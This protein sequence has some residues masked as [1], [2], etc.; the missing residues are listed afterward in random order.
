[1]DLRF[2]RS[3]RRAVA[4]RRE[5]KRR[6]PLAWRSV[7]ATIL[8]LV[9]LTVVAESTRLDGS[10]AKAK[11]VRPRRCVT[12]RT[13]RRAPRCSAARPGGAPL[14]FVRQRFLARREDVLHERR[15]LSQPLG[16]VAPA[17]FE[18]PHLRAQLLLAPADVSFDLP[19]HLLGGLAH[20]RRLTLRI[21]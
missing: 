17:L 15:D 19:H 9:L 12:P 7:Y 20:A 10:D 4:R 6:S 3:L 11:P 21:L 8:A 16:R 5:P 13:S 1:M 14:E 18:H 2:R